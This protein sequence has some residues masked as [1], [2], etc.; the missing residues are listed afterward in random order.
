M[1][2]RANEG[3]SR[4]SRTGGG[5]TRLRQPTAEGARIR[6]AAEAFE[7]LFVQTL[8]AR[9]RQAQLRDGFFGNGPGSVI[10]EGIFEQHLSEVLARRS[11]LGIADL[12][13]ASWKRDPEGADDAENARREVL[14][15]LA[16]RAYEEAAAAV[17]APGTPRGDGSP[18]GLSPPQVS[19]P[20]ADER[21]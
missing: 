21:K 5:S 16:G 14:S 8:L 15:I 12:L 3:E 1:A 10:Y 7:A 20:E 11:P 13:E 2:T 6:Q 19:R 18:R 4:I 17:G 9:M